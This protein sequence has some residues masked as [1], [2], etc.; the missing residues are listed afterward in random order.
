MTSLCDVCYIMPDI[1]ARQTIVYRI[2]TLGGVAKPGSLCG[3]C[4][5][6]IGL[7]P[8]SSNWREQ[9]TRSGTGAWV[10]GRRTMLLAGASIA[11]RPALAALPIPPDN[12]L[13]FRMQRHGSDIGRHTVAFERHGDTLTVHVTVDALVTLLSI[14]IVRYTHRAVE[15]WQG[16]TLIGLSGQTDKNGQQ[17]WVNARRTDEGMVVLGSKTE[18]YIAP[19]QAI[20]T[21]YWNKRMLNGPMISLEDGVLLHPKVV[22]RPAEPIPLASGGQHSGRPLQS[23]RRIQRRCLV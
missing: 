6:P 21:S 15:T 5:P 13:A 20:G 4:L 17:E 16:D 23:Q 2:G 10:I 22:E 7:V 18:R 11:A 12:Q 14:P 8:G 3:C 9:T 1:S 19:P